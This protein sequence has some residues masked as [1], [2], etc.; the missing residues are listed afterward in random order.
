VLVAGKAVGRLLAQVE[1]DVADG[2][3]HGQQAPG[4]GVRLLPVDG[5]VVGAAAV[6]LDELLRLDEHAVGA[7]AGIIDAAL[8]R[9]EHGHQPLKCC[10]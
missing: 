6:R 5:D 1:A 8:V 10:F 7:G 4:G 3:V 2:E 9:G